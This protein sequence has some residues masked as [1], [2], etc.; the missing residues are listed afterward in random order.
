MARRWTKARLSLN[1]EEWPF[2]ALSPIPRIG[3]PLASPERASQRDDRS[4]RFSDPQFLHQIGPTSTT[5][6]GR[7]PIV[8]LQGNRTVGRRGHAG[9]VPRQHGTGA[10]NG[11]SRSSS[12]RR[13]WEFQ[14]AMAKLHPQ[15][16]D[17]PPMWDFSYEVS[18]HPAGLR[19]GAGWWW[20]PARG[21]A[22]TLANGICAGRT[23]WRSFRW[24]NKIDCRPPDPAPVSERSK[25]SSPRTPVTP[26]PVPQDRPGGGT[27]LQ[28]VWIGCRRRPD[29][30]S[31]PL[32]ALN[33]R[34][35]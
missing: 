7:W 10:R 4:S 31:E 32:S 20:M 12:R 22:Q 33:L 16:I 35:S 19:G 3:F 9:P 6:V 13:A 2:G 5:Q 30:L 34:P 17:T 18:P 15:L 11:G 24:L 21:E 28:A 25:R 23:I 26:S 14:A 8:L 29:R 1:R 27:I